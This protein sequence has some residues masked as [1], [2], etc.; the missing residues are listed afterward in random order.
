MA[1]WGEIG[2]WALVNATSE[3]TNPSC[4]LSLIQLIT[5]L[6]IEHMDDTSRFIV[7]VYQFT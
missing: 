4:A 1:F 7:Q 2:C 6:K 3:N 5:A